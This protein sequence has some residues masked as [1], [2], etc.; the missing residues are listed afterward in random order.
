MILVKN[1][2][3]FFGQFCALLLFGLMVWIYFGGDSFTD[4]AIQA[5]YAIAGL[6]WYFWYTSKDRLTNKNN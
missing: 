5:I 1:I 2:I 3:I 6:G 4:R